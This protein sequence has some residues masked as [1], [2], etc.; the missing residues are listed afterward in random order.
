M[1]QL[2]MQATANVAGGQAEDASLDPSLLKQL[3]GV[4]AGWPPVPIGS[5]LPL[6]PA[7]QP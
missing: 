2:S 1:K 6:E 7:P 3:S 5:A 4:Q